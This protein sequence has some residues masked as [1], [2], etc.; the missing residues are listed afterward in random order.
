M[1]AEEIR[2]VVVE[3]LSNIAPETDPASIDPNADVRDALDIDSMDVLNFVIALHKRL[4][5]D[6]PELDYP[7]LHTVAGATAYLTEKLGNAARHGRIG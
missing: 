4:Q 5:L 7:K 2:Q 3:E 1:T 6:I